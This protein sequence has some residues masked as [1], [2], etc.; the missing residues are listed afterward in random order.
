MVKLTMI[1][2]AASVLGSAAVQLVAGNVLRNAADQASG[3]GRPCTGAAQDARL[4]AGP[5]QAQHA[6]PGCEVHKIDLKNA[7]GEFCALEQTSGRLA[8][9]RHPTSG[10]TTGKL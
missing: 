7:C 5:Q 3:L 2:V 1:V 4:P 8:L 6:Q 9:F 10:A